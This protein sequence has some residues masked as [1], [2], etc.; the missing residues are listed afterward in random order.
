MYYSCHSNTMGVTMSA[1]PWGLHVVLGQCAR[2]TLAS[3]VVSLG[4]TAPTLPP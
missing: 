4:L 3:L 1:L 2:P